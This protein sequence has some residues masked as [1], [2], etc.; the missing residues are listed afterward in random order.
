MCVY[1]G[2]RTDYNIITD[3]FRDAL[4]TAMDE[5]IYFYLRIMQ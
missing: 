5:I 3:G 2:E 1:K 4:D